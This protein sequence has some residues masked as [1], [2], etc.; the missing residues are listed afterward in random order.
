MFIHQQLPL[1][2]LWTQWGGGTTWRVIGPAMLQLHQICNRPSQSK[3]STPRKTRWCRLNDC[4]YYV[5][6][7]LLLGINISARYT[8]TCILH[9][10]TPQD[11]LS[12]I[13]LCRIVFVVRMLQIQYIQLCCG[14]QINNPV[15][16]THLHSAACWAKRLWS[17]FQIS[18]SMNTFNHMNQ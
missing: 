3:C 8:F 2:S 13:Y 15:V 6:H 14:V 12:T 10:W 7:P 17:I 11:S 5:I 18:I 16:G 1:E 9:E 4:L